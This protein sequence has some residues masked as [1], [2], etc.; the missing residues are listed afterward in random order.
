MK[1]YDNA[2]KMEGLRHCIG[3]RCDGCDTVNPYFSKKW[4]AENGF[5]YCPD[6]QIFCPGCKVIFS[7]KYGEDWFKDG[8]CEDC[9]EEARNEKDRERKG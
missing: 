1:I 4:L 6:C 7:I 8:L 2:S 3:Y 5:H 9:G